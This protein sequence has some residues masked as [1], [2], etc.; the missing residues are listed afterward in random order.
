MS[1][2]YCEKIILCNFMFGCDVQKY[3]SVFMKIIFLLESKNRNVYKVFFFSNF[4]WSKDICLVGA[5]IVITNLLFDYFRNC[6]KILRL[7]QPS[8]ASSLLSI[9][10]NFVILLLLCYCYYPN[11]LR[12]YK[13]SCYFQ[14]FAL[15]KYLA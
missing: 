12:I 9:F 15:S 5:T 1:F 8:T 2:L 14:S 6:M 7:I 3:F 10:A 11:L 13:I 4:D